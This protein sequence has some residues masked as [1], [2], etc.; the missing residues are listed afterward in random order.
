MTLPKHT[1][2]HFKN[3]RQTR[4]FFESKYCVEGLC[5][6]GWN[7]IPQLKQSSC[8]SSK[9]LKLLTLC[10]ILI[11]NHWVWPVLFWDWS[12]LIP[13]VQVHQACSVA[14]IPKLQNCFTPL[15]WMAFRQTPSTPPPLPCTHTV[16]QMV[17]ST[18]LAWSLS[19]YPF[20]SDQE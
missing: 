8:F 10:C 11:V 13:V 5:Y 15:L 3:L 18:W 16:L 2:W 6:P 9:R 4:L 19:S 7:Q 20:V 1:S 17:Q 14:L 12:S